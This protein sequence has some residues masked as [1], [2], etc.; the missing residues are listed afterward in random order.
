MS[1]IV[2]IEW[3]HIDDGFPVIPKGKYGVSVLVVRYDHMCG[4]CGYWDVGH[5][6]YASTS[7]KKGDKK[8]WFENSD[9]E[10]DFME[11]YYGPEDTEWGPTGDPVYY[12]AYM[13]EMPNFPTISKNKS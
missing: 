12:W 8:R 10:F 2:E 11:L 3:V 13:P 9:R 5:A 6:L 7:D 1:E 4:P